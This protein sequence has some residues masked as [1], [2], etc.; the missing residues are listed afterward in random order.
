MPRAGL[1][2]PANGPR[3][4]AAPH[5]ARLEG[6]NLNDAEVEVCYV[7]HR[8]GACGSYGIEVIRKGDRL[9]VQG[10]VPD[11][12]RKRDLLTAIAGTGL[13]GTVRP[14]IKTAAEVV[15]GARNAGA[16]EAS[17]VLVGRAPSRLRAE[18]EIQEYVAKHPEQRGER[19]TGPA[20]MTSIANDAIGSA[21][22]LLDD[23]WELR[24]LAAHYGD[25]EA[26]LSPSSRELLTL[27]MRDHAGSMRRNL[28]ALAARLAPLLSRT[29]EVLPRA[30]AIGPDAADWRR[31][32]EGLFEAARR[33]NTIVGK[34]F[35]GG[36]I[37]SE[38][39]TRV[40][41]E[42]GDDVPATM[43]DLAL[44]FSAVNGNAAAL[45]EPS[46]LGARR[47]P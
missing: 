24:R 5:P 13:A 40:S 20:E 16:S 47:N 36:V 43:H 18:I 30:A 21:G 37:I 6:V 10:V 9:V 7:L 35:A 45:R 26:E 12:E 39:G 19:L 33:L 22:A 46:L 1:A 34:L 28:A 38:N 44:A 17:P 27:I 15:D 3:P 25:G 29:G 32:C 2:L 14:D 8:R 31:S 41:P 42:S 4:V 23:A 11:E